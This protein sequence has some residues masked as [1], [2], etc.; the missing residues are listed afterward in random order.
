MNSKF[1][2]G[3]YLQIPL[4]REPSRSVRL[5]Q[6]YQS[7]KA[8][9]ATDGGYLKPTTFEVLK[10]SSK[11]KP[12]VYD[13]KQKTIPKKSHISV[14][15][16]PQVSTVHEACKSSEVKVASI[17]CDE[18][19]VETGIMRYVIPSFRPHKLKDYHWINY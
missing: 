18:E 8:G 2:G 12:V 10:P 15:Y 11:S 7:Y 9:Y 19:I 5:R 1:S 3:G 6:P 13:I 17:I 16:N 14:I 4:K